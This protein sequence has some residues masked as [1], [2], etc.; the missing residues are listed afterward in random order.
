MSW[1]DYD[2]NP[3]EDILTGVFCNHTLRVSSLLRGATGIK[4]IDI[5]HKLEDHIIELQQMRD[6][7]VKEI[8]TTRM[9][10]GNNDE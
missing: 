8:A 2:S 10:D 3:S 5:I 9:S 4:A 7:L 6:S 1:S